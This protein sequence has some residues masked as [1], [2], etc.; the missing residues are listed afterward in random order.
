MFF[1]LQT[2]YGDIGIVYYRNI[3]S[4]QFYTKIAKFTN[5]LSDMLPSL[6]GFWLQ[7]YCVRIIIR[8]YK[9]TYL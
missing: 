1:F 2:R 9:T 5:E 3:I 4:L 6:P 7:F 8:I